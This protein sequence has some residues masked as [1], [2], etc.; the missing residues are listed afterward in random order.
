MTIFAASPLLRPDLAE[1]LRHGEAALRETRQS[2]L[3]QFGPREAIV[4]AG[5]PHDHV[6]WLR[7][8]WVCRSRPHPDGGRRIISLALPGDLV[9][10][11]NLL[12]ARHADSLECLTGVT[13]DS[14]SRATLLRMTAERPEVALRVTFQLAEEERRLHNWVIGLLHGGAEERIA[15]LLLGLRERLRRLSLVDADAFHLPMTQRQI[16]DHVGLTFVHVGRVLRRLRTGR[17]AT[18]HRASVIIHDPATLE[19]IARPI[20]DL[21]GGQA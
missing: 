15:V 21:C 8:G 7:S 5:E 11:K 9:G 17:V 3:H 18:V 13:A 20:L 12:F 16:G 2:G 4:A 6:Y 1:T 14:Y 19:R 10:L